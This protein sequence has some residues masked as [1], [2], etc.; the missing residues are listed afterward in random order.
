M[1]N[2]AL[3]ANKQSLVL[4]DKHFLSVSGVSDVASFDEQNIIA[5]T[6]LGELTVSGS[7]LKINT[8]STQTGDLSVEGNIV[9]LVFSER[10]ESGGG[11]FSRIFR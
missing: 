10:T 6:V 7:E 5:Q 3:G 11:F 8:F 2:N 4:E 1:E 9:A